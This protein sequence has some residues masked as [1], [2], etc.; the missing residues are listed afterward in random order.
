M[1]ALALALV[2]LGI[3]PSASAQST[4]SSASTSL[5]RARIIAEQRARDERARDHEP[6]A[7]LGLDIAGALLTVGGIQA[8]WIGLLSACAG[9]D[10]GP[11]T[12]G[13]DGPLVAAMIG[14]GAAGAG[15]VCFLV[16]AGFHVDAASRRAHASRQVSLAPGPG[17]LSLALRISLDG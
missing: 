14:A 11:R 10:P 1:R 15:L 16:A 13:Q 9:C 12:I 7:A 17:E 2:L 4:S 8:L 3:A 5:A 6:A